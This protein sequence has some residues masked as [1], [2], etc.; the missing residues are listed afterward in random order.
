MGNALQF[1]L[2]D[3]SI[4]T[5]NY[6]FG[7]IGRLEFV[8][9]NILCGPWDVATNAFC[10]ICKLFVVQKGAMVKGHYENGAFIGHCTI[11]YADG[12]VLSG[13]FA[14]NGASCCSTTYP[15][16]MTKHNVRTNKIW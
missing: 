2:N 15:V 1:E 16:H 7:T 11:I 5:L 14:K 10:G 13:F 12:Q 9:G 8:D 4:L 6:S 3:G